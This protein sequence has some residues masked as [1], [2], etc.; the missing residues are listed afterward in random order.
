[1]P[2]SP[3]GI[4]V[5][6]GRTSALKRLRSSRVPRRIAT[7]INNVLS[8]PAIGACNRAD[9]GFTDQ[10]DF[11]DYMTGMR[12]F[13]DNYTKNLRIQ[14]GSA[15]VDLEAGTF[16]IGSARSVSTISCGQTYRTTTGAQR[17]PVQT[18]RF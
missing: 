14:C 17:S 8:S 11:G 9:G 18:T 6:R 15:T 3:I 2:C 16:R 5:T 12:V 1:M 10:E 4:S 7:T 13:D